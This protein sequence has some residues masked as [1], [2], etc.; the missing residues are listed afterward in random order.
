MKHSQFRWKLVDDFV[1]RFNDYHAE[2]FIPSK[3]ICVDESISRWYGQVGGWI[4][5]GLSHYVAIHRKPENGC[6][7]Q[8]SCCGVSGIMM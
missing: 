1:K 6:E 5:T 8:D 7:I 2:N 3:M 4:N